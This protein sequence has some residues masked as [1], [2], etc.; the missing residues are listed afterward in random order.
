MKWIL[1]FSTSSLLFP[2]GSLFS[3]PFI[4]SFYSFSFLPSFGSIFLLSSSST[5]FSWAN[6]PDATFLLLLRRWT[7]KKVSSKA[8]IRWKYLGSVTRKWD[9]EKKTQAF[10]E[11]F[12]F[13]I[14]P[15]IQS[16]CASLHKRKTMLASCR[17]Y[18][19]LHLL[20]FSI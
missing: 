11:I 20:K 14:L 2:S 8:C 6:Y 1:I 12:A 5:S 13:S 19:L 4:F 10:G 3:L 9:Q 7:V 16:A 18:L 17:A 15:N